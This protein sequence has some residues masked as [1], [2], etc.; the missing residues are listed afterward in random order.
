MLDAHRH[1]R[2][3][4]VFRAIDVAGEHDTVIVDHGVRGLDRLHLDGRV[5]RIGVAGKL[6][7]EDL[8]KASAQGEHLEAARV[9]VG[10]PRPVHERRE[11]PGLVD[12]VGTWLEIE[13]IGVGQH[14]L[15]AERS[16]HLRGE[17]LDVRLGSHGNE[18]RCGNAAVRCVNNA[19][20]PQAALGLQA[21]ADLESAVGAVGSR[22]GRG[23]ERRDLF[24]GGGAEP[25][26]IH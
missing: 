1:L 14:R 22:R 12:D 25:V 9:R 26:S 19:G 20:P 15:S 3:E 13:M 16:H 4:A 24:G 17:R 7:R 23:W 2:I 5:A 8:L 10:W 21:R 11:A 18:G 6:L